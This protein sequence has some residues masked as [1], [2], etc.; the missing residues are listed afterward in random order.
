MATVVRRQKYQASGAL[1]ITIASMALGA[2][3]C[4]T[5]INN[6]DTGLATAGMN[7]DQ[8]IIH[9]K[10]R[11][12]AVAP[13][14]G[15]TVEFYLVRG[16]GVSH[17]DAGLSVSN[18]AVSTSTLRDQLELLYAVPVIASANQSYSVSFIIYNPSECWSIMMWNATDQALDTTAGN[19]YINYEAITD[20]FI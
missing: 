12:G 10:F 14:A 15:K 11:M 17:V 3:Q 19:H 16:D 18:A 2:G 13:T 1:V 9:A 5:Q 4:S 7:V 6:N 8:I 20:S